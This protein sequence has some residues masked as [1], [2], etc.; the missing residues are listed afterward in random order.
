MFSVSGE[1]ARLQSELATGDSVGDTEAGQENTLSG[2][3]DLECVIIVIVVG[4][5]SLNE[6][7]V[8]GAIE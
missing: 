1:V 5:N 6:F 3:K 2:V 7:S 4:L 8:V